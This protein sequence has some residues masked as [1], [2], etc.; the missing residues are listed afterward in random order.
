[1]DHAKFGAQPCKGGKEGMTVAST[2]HFR[3]ADKKAQSEIMSVNGDGIK[4]GDVR[5]LKGTMEREEGG[6]SARPGR[7]RR[8]KGPSPA[9]TQCC[10]DTRRQETAIACIVI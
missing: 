10:A 1:M 5:D 7:D 8:H 2:V 9:D 3:D 6:G 4:S